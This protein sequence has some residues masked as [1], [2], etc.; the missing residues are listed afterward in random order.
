MENLDEIDFFTDTSIVSNSW[1]YYEHLRAKGPV[2]RLPTHHN[3]VAVTGYKEG[4]AVFRDEENFSSV[5]APNG[6][7]PPLPFAPEGDDITDQI[8]RHRHE[9]PFGDLIATQDPPTHTRLKPIMMGM[10][11]PRRLKENEEAMWGFADRQMDTFLH[12]GSFEAIADY[13]H[14]FSGQVI[15]D[16]LGVPSEDHDKIQIVRPSIPGQVGV[17]GGENANDIFHPTHSYFAQRLE[18]RRRDPRPDVLGNLAQVRYADGSLPA[19]ADVVKV[20]GSIYGAAQ[21]TV[22][23]LMATTLRYVAEDCELQEKIRNR[24]EL[25][26]ALVE[27][28]LRLEGSTKSEFR[29]VKRSTK[30]GDLEL[31]A[32]M[33]VMLLIHA[34]NR[35]PTRFENPNEL[36]LERRNMREHIAFGRGIHACVG[37][38]LA[39]AEAVITLQRFMDRTGDI[40]IDEAKHGPAGARRYDYMPSYLM[41]GL[42]HLHLTFTM[43]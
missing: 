35:D 2:V 14:P 26:P 43:V 23:R 20:A 21:G 34:M 41:H 29:L 6:P 11:T 17:G 7:L 13:A 30:V 28:A 12:R 1:P 42:D 36:N 16:L 15:G 39:R 24:P 32:G 5:I 8:E 10:I 19:V 9:I 38:P 27:E 3:V 25:I 40:R 37:A 4:L 22:T 31:K 33:I 18:E